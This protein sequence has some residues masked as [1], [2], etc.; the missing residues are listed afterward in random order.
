[1]ATDETTSAKV[2]TAQDRPQT[3]AEQRAASH[4]GT[5][6]TD[7]LVSDIEKTRGELAETLDAI[8]DKVDP[9][10]VADRTK[11]QA[12]EAAKDGV[13]DAKAAATTAAAAVKGAVK[14]KVAEVK[15]KVSGSS[16]SEPV[17]SPLAP[18]TSVSVDAATPVTGAPTTGAAAAG[19]A[20]TAGTSPLPS[21]AQSVDAGGL[22]PAEPADTPGSLADRSD[23]TAPTVEPA[24][25]DL[26]AWS[27][28][29]PAAYEPSQTPA[30]VGAGAAAAAAVGAALVLLVLR[31]R[32]G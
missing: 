31:R 30:M 18:A 2:Q 3:A 7:Q 15:E 26:P 13:E 12:R 11:A 10:K 17:R 22:P 16:D 28:A 5:T 21:N 20:A 1:M 4:D 6:D 9:K 14:E 23:A 29:R 25:A 19:T 24:G 8:V 32:R 27:P